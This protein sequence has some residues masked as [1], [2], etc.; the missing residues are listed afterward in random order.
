MSDLS[1]C[2]AEYMI[3]DGR[4]L[5]LAEQ[6]LPRIVG[7]RA[8]AS[9]KDGPVDRAPDQ[10]PFIDTDL[11]WTNR[12]TEPQH[13]RVSVERA[14]RT[15]ISSNT[16]VLALDDAM[17]WA[18][19]VSPSAPRPQASRSGLGVRIALTRASQPQIQFGR[20]FADRDGWCSY[21]DVG[22]VPPGESVHFRYMCLFST[23]GPWRTAPLPRH[24]A[25]ARWVRLRMWASPHLTAI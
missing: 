25:Y 16:N 6:W 14:S 22:L 24:E 23:P 4:G 17:S 13:V 15:L 10:I 1:V 20:I 3:S 7:E 12:S 8:A 9:T 5:R 2:T 19:G 18:I 21:E 11:T